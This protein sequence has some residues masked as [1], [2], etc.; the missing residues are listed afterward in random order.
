MATSVSKIG[1]LVAEI[2]AATQEQAKGIA[3]ISTAV[4][5]MSTSV[6]KNASFSAETASAFTQRTTQAEALHECRVSLDAIVNG[7]SHLP[8][9]DAEQER[10]TEKSRCY[11]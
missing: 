11:S 10:D 1:G 8:V 3:E 6:Q 7:V 5:Q 9:T 2:A 4:A